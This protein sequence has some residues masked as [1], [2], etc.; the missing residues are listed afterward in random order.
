MHTHTALWHA[1]AHRK[2]LLIYKPAGTP[3]HTVVQCTQVNNM[4]EQHCGT[5]CITQ[6]H[7]AQ[8]NTEVH[9]AQNWGTPMDETRR[10]TQ[11]SAGRI[12]LH[13]EGGGMVIIRLHYYHIALSFNITYRG[14]FKMAPCLWIWHLNISRR[15][16]Q[17]WM[18]NKVKDAKIIQMKKKTFGLNIAWN[19]QCKDYG[20]ATVWPVVI[21]L[22]SGHTHT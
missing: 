12:S 9:N 17:S 14:M 10:G 20:K 22:S 1:A 4:E 13:Q 7:N 3:H 6:W 16:Y 15:K 21:N 5:K 2:R 18:F 11:R 8:N 19:K